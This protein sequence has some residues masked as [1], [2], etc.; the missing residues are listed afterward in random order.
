MTSDDSHDEIPGFTV[1]QMQWSAEDELSSSLAENLQALESAVESLYR[2]G[3]AIRQSSS[4]NITQRVNAFMEKQNDVNLEN[5]VFPRAKFENK[6]WWERHVETD[7]RLYACI[8]EE[9]AD[10][11]QLFA[12]FDDWRKHMDV[13][14]T[15][16][17]TQRIHR[18]LMLHIADHVKRAG[19]LSI[20]YIQDYDQGG[21][22][23]SGD[24][25]GGVDENQEPLDDRVWMDGQWVLADAELAA[26]RDPEILEVPSAPELLSYNENWRFIYE[27]LSGTPDSENITLKSV[28]KRLQENFKQSR[29]WAEDSGDGFLPRKALTKILTERTIQLL[30][31]QKHETSH[32]S[33]TDIIGEKKRIKIFAILILIKKTEHIS[34]SKVSRTM[35]CLWNRST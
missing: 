17:W 11:P 19:F 25:S 31:K 12:R 21:E 10:P 30:L 13:E 9:C 18:P 16:K 26:Y 35:T 27:P 1:E 34:S 28:Q 32:I 15:P 20:D 3:I 33:S 7:F 8:W 22:Q 4:G 6:A 29:A 14:H 24:T 23:G 2:L 5:M